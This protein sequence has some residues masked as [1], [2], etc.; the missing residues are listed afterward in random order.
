MKTLSAIAVLAALLPA[1]AVA[2]AMPTDGEI[3]EILATRIDQQHW[4]TGIVVGLVTPQ[5]TRTI[6]YGTATK[7]GTQKVDANTVYDI[8]SITKAFT[9]LALADMAQH[10]EVALD[11]Q[12]A[13]YLPKDV[14]LPKDSM[15]QITLADLATHTAGYLCGL[16]ISHLRTPITNT[17]STARP[18]SIDSSPT[19][20]R[21]IP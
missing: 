17:R 6:A 14:V 7:D 5:G 18:I 10:G 9:A 16:K 8:G 19:T 20:S 21:C 11:D 1:T 13:K 12:V 3:Q 15:R 2:Q 4:A